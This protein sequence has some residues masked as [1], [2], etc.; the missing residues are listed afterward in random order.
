MVCRKYVRLQIYYVMLQY[1]TYWLSN[2]ICSLYTLLLDY[3]CRVLG[4]FPAEMCPTLCLD[5]RLHVTTSPL[6]ILTY[7][8]IFNAS[9]PVVKSKGSTKSN[10]WLTTGIRISCTTKR[11]LY[12]TYR[13][14]MDPNY[15]AYYK[16]YCKIL[17]PAIRAAK[18]KSTLIP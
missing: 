3:P 10:P 16:K 9:F 14:S 17:S 13:N 7:L 12:A 18:K 8:R 6:Y 11:N 1:M 5:L 15:K 2:R 4:T